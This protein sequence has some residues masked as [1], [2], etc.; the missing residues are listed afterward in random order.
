MDQS[1]LLSIMATG[2]AVAFLHAAI[3]THWLPFVLASR[4]Q[5]WTKIKTLLVVASSGGGHVLFTTILG[6]LVVWLGIETS[7]WTGNIFPW[8]A[9][10]A[11]ILFGLYYL[12]RQLRGHGHG[13]HHWTFGR[14]HGHEHDHGPDHHHGHAHEGHRHSHTHDD[15]HHG[16]EKR[17]DTGHG[18]VVIE[19]FEAG[20]PPVFRLRSTTGPLPQAGTLSLETVRPDGS[21]QRF[22]FIEREGLLESREQ[23]PNLM[24][25]S[26][27]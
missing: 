24:K 23:S 3:P 9:G 11:L 21:R 1:L 17:I 2:F 13:H 6:V 12:V 20:V 18:T 19:I 4:G 8:I 27:C 14:G 7:Q 15:H 5:G 26:R 16:E 10:G 25:S 22:S